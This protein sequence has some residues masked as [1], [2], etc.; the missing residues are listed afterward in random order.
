MTESTTMMEQIRSSDQQHRRDGEGHGQQSNSDSS[1]PTAIER[2]R[3]LVAAS[4]WRVCVHGRVH[5]ETGRLRG[6]GERPVVDDD[7]CITYHRGSAS[8]PGCVRIARPLG[9]QILRGPGCRMQS[10]NTQAGGGRERRHMNNEQGQ[11]EDS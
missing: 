3:P 11:K 1:S 8:R 9:D 7:R 4:G 6:A 10:Q 5:D 2:A